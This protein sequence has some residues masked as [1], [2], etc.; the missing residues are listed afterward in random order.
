[1]RNAGSSAGS[2]GKYPPRDG[3]GRTLE[4]AVGMIGLCG[5]LDECPGVGRV[6][7]SQFLRA[8]KSVPANVEEARAAQGKADLISK[9]SL[10]LKE[11][12]ETRLRLRLLVPAK[13]VSAKDLNPLIQE[14]DE[15]KR[16][17]GAIIV[18]TKRGGE[19]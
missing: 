11:A 1:M 15:I 7:M 13:V 9:M 19:A 5:K 10:P 14:A 12:R 8:G 4:F 6:M 18:S 16:G 17:L 3:V 2:F